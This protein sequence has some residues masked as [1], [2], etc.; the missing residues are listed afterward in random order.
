M[1]DLELDFTIVQHAYGKN[2]VVELKPGGASIPVTNASRVE[3]INLVANYKL[4]KQVSRWL[5]ST[6]SLIL[7]HLVVRTTQW[8]YSLL[9]TTGS[10]S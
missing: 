10:S 8:N 7:S 4:N 9:Y 5:I 3:Y 2:T 1:R 6:L